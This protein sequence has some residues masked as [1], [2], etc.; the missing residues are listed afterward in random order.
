M[1]GVADFLTS[2]GSPELALSVCEISSL[3]MEMKE[4]EQGDQQVHTCVVGAQLRAL[5]RM[6]RGTTVKELFDKV[7]YSHVFY[8]DG[9]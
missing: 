8:G 3:P 1:A 2:Q 5:G 4:E 9:W 6:N 7:S